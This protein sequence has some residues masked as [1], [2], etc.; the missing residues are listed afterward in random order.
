MFFSAIVWIGNF[1]AFTQS[2][3]IAHEHNF[4][5]MRFI[6]QQAQNI[7]LITFVHSEYVIE[8]CQVVGCKLSAAM[9]DRYSIFARVCSCTRVGLI[10]SM[11]IRCSARVYLKKMFETFFL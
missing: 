4:L 3:E 1:F 8:I 5:C 10:A 9:I 6:F 11:V 2:I 7:V